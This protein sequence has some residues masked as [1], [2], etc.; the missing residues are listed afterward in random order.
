MMSMPVV[1]EDMHERTGQ[2][3]EVGQSGRNVDQ[4]LLQ[5]KVARHGPYDDEADGV[6]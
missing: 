3:E 2:Y 5:K 6:A 4:M 1:H